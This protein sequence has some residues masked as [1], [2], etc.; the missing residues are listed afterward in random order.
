MTMGSEHTTREVGCSEPAFFM[1]YV[2]IQSKR[3]SRK[4]G[5]GATIGAG[6]NNI[7]SEAFYEDHYE[8]FYDFYDAENYFDEHN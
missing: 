7:H 6:R 4:R 8:D 3:A 2:M 1:F 5:S